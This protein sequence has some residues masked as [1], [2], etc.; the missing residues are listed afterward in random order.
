M[1][2]FLAFTISMTDLMS[3]CTSAE[4]S[5]QN[6][7]QRIKKRIF[8]S[9]NRAVF[10]F[11]DLANQLT[12]KLLLKNTNRV[13]THVISQTSQELLTLYKHIIVYTT[14]STISL[15]LCYFHLYKH[16][17]VLMS[18]PLN[19]LCNSNHLHVLSVLRTIKI[20]HKKTWILF[21]LVVMIT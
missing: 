6:L 14:N 19:T 16:T 12:W 15:F 7:S 18:F 21:I 10:K 4:V 9:T 5:P 1:R 8:L 17:F 3:G 11:R 2:F 13:L 20:F